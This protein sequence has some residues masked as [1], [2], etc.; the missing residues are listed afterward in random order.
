MSTIQFRSVLALLLLSSACGTQQGVPPPA[1]PP[2]VIV[3]PHD[4]APV[5][6]PLAPKSRTLNANELAQMGF[7]IP[8]N[9]AQWDSLPPQPG[10]QV[11]GLT[12]KGGPGA[13]TNWTAFTLILFAN[14]KG[15]YEVLTQ[16]RTI[17]PS[18]VIETPGGHLTGGQSW[19][20]GAVTEIQQE[21]G[22]KLHESDLFYL[23]GGKLGVSKATGKLYGNVNFFAVFTGAKPTT[24]VTSHEVDASY[25]H[26]WLPLEQIYTDAKTEQAQAGFNQGKYYSFFRQQLISFVENVLN[27][28]FSH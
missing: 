17:K 15:G 22:I 20:T 9:Q 23:E 10:Q 8:G 11:Q 18:G 6:A 3:A 21:S 25:G 4:G 1:P 19:R 27:K 12:V 2:Q 14:N 5:Q 16:K 28:K 13:D 7:Q 26:Q 24:A